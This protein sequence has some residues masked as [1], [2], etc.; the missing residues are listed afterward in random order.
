ME[1]SV[2]KIHKMIRILTVAPL[3]AIVTLSILL[4]FRKE[5]YPNLWYYL[6]S[7]CFLGLL[8]LLAYPLQRFIPPFKNQGRKGQRNLAIIFAVIGY[9]LGCIVGLFASYTK[10]LWLIYLEYL[11]SGLTIAIVNKCFHLKISGH[12]CGMIGPVMLFFYFKLYIMAMIGLFIAVI[13]YISSIKMK[14]HTFYQL[15]GGSLVP[16]IAILILILILN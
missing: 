9:I 5:V 10:E 14:R 4:I 11:L 8:P 13:V 6:F 7:L 2:N 3:M 15:L 16:I 1:K 12:A